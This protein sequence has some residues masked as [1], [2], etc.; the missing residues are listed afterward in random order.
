[1]ARFR[2]GLISEGPL[3]KELTSLRRERAAVRSQLR[4]AER[5]AGTRR[6]ARERLN[7][8]VSTLARIREA[9]AIATP[10]DRQGIARTMIDPG[11]VT[12]R[13]GAIYVDLFVPRPASTHSNGHVL[14]SV[15]DFSDV[16]ESRLRIRLVA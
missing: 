16:H 12:L 6:S 1:M 11:G 13:D 10:E 15:G 14:V 9:A 7:E 5:A 8:A 2:R 3:D 4:F